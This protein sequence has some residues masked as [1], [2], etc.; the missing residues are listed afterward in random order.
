MKR[1]NKFLTLILTMVAVIAIT[2]CVQDDDYTIPNSLGN[3]ENEALTEL[4][5][6]LNDVNSGVTALTVTQVKKLYTDYEEEQSGFDYDKFYQIL[7]DVVVKGYV[8]SSDATGNFYKEF[9]IQDSPTNPTAAIQIVL[10]QADSYNQYNQGREVYIKLKD[11]YVG[12]TSSEVIAIGGKTDDDEVGQFTAVQV[13]DYILRSANTEAITPLE[14]SFSAINES[15]VGMFVKINNAEFPSYLNGELYGDSS[16]DFDTQREL[17]ACDG[18]SYSNFILETSSFANFYNTALPLDKGGSI[19][20]IVTKSYGGDNLVLAL[21]SLNDVVFD[22]ERCT[23]L[24]LDMFDVVFE[25]DFVGGLNGWDV[26]NTEGTQSWYAASFGGDS[27][28]RGSGYDGSSAVT[29]VS[30]LISPS[31]D[32]DAQEGE[33]MVLEI[34]DAFSD[35][36][37]EPL[38]AYY[39][40]DY[41]A[42]SDPSTATWVEV[43]TDEIEALPINGGFF[44]NIYNETGF[45]D[46]SAPTGNGFIAFVYDS[47]DAAISSTRDLGNVKILAPQ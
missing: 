9:Y 8:S 24:S 37:E 25:E 19:A 45:I 35:A 38:K 33:Q 14:L 28:V 16:E 30:W 2:S 41:V 7:S 31:F 17:Q 39:S 6:Q 11:T 44:D 40:T 3:D 46:L 26:I 23:P 21:N 47:D 43:G 42:G 18:F 10:N 13:P 12:L 5:G 20:G 34:A 32:F 36:G 4:L 22:Q 1:T 27:Y 29:M 15:H